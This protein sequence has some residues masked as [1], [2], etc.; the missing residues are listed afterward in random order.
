MCIYIYTHDVYTRGVG[1]VEARRSDE[2]GYGNVGKSVSASERN[3]AVGT[4]FLRLP[5]H[6][7]DREKFTGD[8]AGG[9]HPREP[10]M[11]LEEVSGSVEYPAP[12]GEGRI[13]I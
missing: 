13:K 4:A 1:R 6:A 9:E 10:I 3:E 12:D 2:R 7:R 11:A 8:R 5:R